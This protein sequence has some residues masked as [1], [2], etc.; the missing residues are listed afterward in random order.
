MQEKDLGAL[1]AELEAQKGRLDAR[2]ARI[3]ANVRR[4]LDADSKERAKEL[5]D[6]E[7]VDALGIET[8]HE[9]ILIN[10]ALRRMDDGSYGRCADCDEPIASERLLASP[11][12][13]LCIDCAAL[14]ERRRAQP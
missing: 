13:L 4:T 2:L 6:Q 10:E 14:H 12:V 8:T 9:L 5:E 3:K 7:V 11:H 1:R